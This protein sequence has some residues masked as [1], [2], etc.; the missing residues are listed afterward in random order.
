[1]LADGWEA[2][3]RARAIKT[4]DELTLMRQ[5]AAVADIAIEN[6]RQ[7][8]RP[9]VTEDRVVVDTRGYEPEIRGRAHRWQAPGIRGQHEP[10]VQGHIGKTGEA[11][12]HWSGSTSTWQARWATSCAYPATY[13]CGDGNPSD[14]QMDV[15]KTG[16]EFIQAVDGPVQARQQLPG[17][18][19]KGLPVPGEVQGAALPGDVPRRG[20]V[21][22][23]ARHRL[24]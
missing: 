21:R 14:A 7:A 5:A 17:N 11:G 23:M 2:I 4:P 24:P 3:E 10:L 12:G 6:T 19:R 18:S 1:M 16:Y 8:I 22:R 13:L 20:D 15:Y 9:G